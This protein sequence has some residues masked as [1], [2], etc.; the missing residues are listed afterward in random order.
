MGMCS[1]TYGEK[2]TLSL[3]FV[4]FCQFT[5]ERLAV[6]PGPFHSSE[7]SRTG[8]DRELEI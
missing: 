5:C 4:N 7:V 1:S 8:P 2:H 3:E 6:F